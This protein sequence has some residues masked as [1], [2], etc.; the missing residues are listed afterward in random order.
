MKHEKDKFIG[1][2]SKPLTLFNE[3]IK[4]TKNKILIVHF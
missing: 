2:K 3:Y 4:K 1:F